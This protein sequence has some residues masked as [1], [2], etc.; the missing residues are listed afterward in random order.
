MLR[1][2]ARQTAIAPWCI[3]TT[4]NIKLRLVLNAA[5]KIRRWTAL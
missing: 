5:H 1:F 4:S 3:S 2:Q